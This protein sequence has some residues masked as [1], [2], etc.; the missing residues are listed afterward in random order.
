MAFVSRAIL[1][2]NR[3][4]RGRNC[5]NSGWKAESRFSLVRTLEM[6]RKS[7]KKPRFH[8]KSRGKRHDFKA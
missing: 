1:L 6:E 5:S 8:S 3:L 7:S 2:I 4:Y